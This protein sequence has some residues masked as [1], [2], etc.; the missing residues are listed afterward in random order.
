MTEQFLKGSDVVLIF[1][2]MRSETMAKRMTVSVFVY[3]GF[4]NCNADGFLVSIAV[5]TLKLT[6][7]EDARK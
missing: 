5:Q 6:Y 2:Q 1:E 7:F 4:F 3:F